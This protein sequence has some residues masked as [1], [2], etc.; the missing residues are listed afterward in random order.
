MRR[1]V[2]RIF[3]DPCG[4]PPQSRVGVLAPAFITSIVA[5]TGSL[6]ADPT[7]S[8]PPA[9]ARDQAAVTSRPASPESTTPDID[10]Y[11]PSRAVGASRAP[12]PPAYV[13]PLSA[14]RLGLDQGLDWLLFGVEQRTRYELRRNNYREGLADSEL[15][16]TR[17]RVYLGVEEVVDPLRLG[18]EF[19]DSRQFGGDLPQNNNRVDEADLLQGF[20]EFFVKDLL[21]EGRPLRLQAGRLSDDYVD[22]RMRTR[23]GFRNTT[24]AFDGLRLQL[25]ERSSDWEI[26]VFASRPVERRPVKPDRPEEDRLFYG[27]AGAWRRWR[28]VVFIEPYY[29]ALDRRARGYRAQNS[30]THSFGLHLYGP[31]GKT[32]LDYDLDTAIQYGRDAGLS[33]R[34]FATHVELGYTLDHRWKPR[35][36]AWVNYA[37]GDRDPQ[38]RVLHRFVPPFGNSHSM[39][40]YT[41]FFT[42]RNLV[43]PAIE[44]RLEPDRNTLLAAIYRGYWLASR[45]DEWE[46]GGRVDPTGKSGRFIGHEIDLF[47]RRRLTSH[48]MVEIGYAHFFPGAFTRNTGESPDADL[49]YVHTFLEF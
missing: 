14:E 47:L 2:S 10:W 9:P 31:V 13:R 4:G 7:R 46:R 28:E 20:V 43:N 40:G 3:A 1:F 22:R 27:V 21:G 36:A 33:H 15:F 17:S 48:L 30:E 34:A 12:E 16:L 42:W 37:S 39:Y 11:Q 45:R 5:A 38:D 26:D 19:Q 23:N 44:I 49:F 8:A 24:N 35:L 32:P 25:G 6:S 29:F 41:D 18:V